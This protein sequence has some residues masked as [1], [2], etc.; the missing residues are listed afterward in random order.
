MSFEPQARSEQAAILTVSALN[1]AASRILERTFPALWVQGEVSN[2]TRA[3]SGH[4]YFT[5]KDD[6]AQVR[7]VMFK[8]RSQYVDFMPREGDH[9]EVRGTVT[10]YAPR[11]DYQ[12]NIDTMRRAGTGNLYEA[13]LQLKNKLEREGLFD[14]D[15][16]KAI[17][18][19]AHTIG[20]VSS[21][22]AAAL[23]DIL[24]TLQRRSPHVQVILYP[25]PVQGE[26][27]PQKIAQAI[28][29]A[30]SR[31]ECDVLLVCRGGGSIED[32]WSFN[33]EVVARAIA[34]CDIPVISG[35]GHETDFTIADFVADL[36]APTPTAA[37]ELAATSYNDLMSQIYTC[38]REMQLAFNRQLTQHTQTIDI[39][40]RRLISPGAYVRQERARLQNTTLRLTH[41]IQTQQAQYRYRLQQSYNR[42]TRLIQNTDT[43]RMQ[44]NTRADRLTNAFRQQQKQWRTTLTY[45]ATRL[46]SLS[47]QQTLNR[48]YAI[49]TDHHGHV[50]QAPDA[51]KARSTIN[52]RLAKGNADITIQSVQAALPEN[53]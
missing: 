38:A 23:R 3:A 53:E 40:A 22:Q 41:L 10:L 36:R 28:I 24:T 50:I 13:F 27:S 7:S 6:A 49:V 34:A 32:L 31:H 35:V 51:L 11:G 12:L 15:R 45:V 14:A 46:H 19:F 18:S 1:Q 29:T 39:L 33:E 25:T 5:L 9:V 42:V 4:W 44:L 2:F 17:P 43:P 48:G 20:V 37:A 8:G 52:L 21:P 26:G 47:P 16:K 30:T